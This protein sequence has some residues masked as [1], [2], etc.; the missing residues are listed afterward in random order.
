V[1]IVRSDRE[2]ASGARVPLTAEGSPGP[3][4]GRAAWRHGGSEAAR[5]RS[6]VGGRAGGWTGSPVIAL[7]SACYRNSCA[8]PF[9]HRSHSS[10]VAVLYRDGPLAVVSVAGLAGR[11]EPWRGW[12]RRAHEFA[13]SDSPLVVEFTNLGSAIQIE[14]VCAGGLASRSGLQKL[15]SPNHKTNCRYEFRHSFRN[16][17]TYL[18]IA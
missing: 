14:F 3:A 9:R 17:T 18:G 5:Q 2:I 15:T 16:S 8:R 4:G 1:K 12:A 11:V 10:I 7:C 6:R 13:L